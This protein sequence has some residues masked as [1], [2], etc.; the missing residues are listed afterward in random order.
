MAK[1]SHEFAHL[2]HVLVEYGAVPAGDERRE[3]LRDKL[4]V[5]FRPVAVNIA[6]RYSGRGEPLDDLEQVA[7]IGLLHALDRFEPAHGRDFLAYAVPTIMGEVRRYFRDSAWSVKTPRS[8]KDRYVAVNAS[9]A[10]VAQD[11]GRAPTASELAAR[12]GLSREEVLEAVAARSSF[13]SASL[14]EALADD[15]TALIDILGVID[16]DLEH[17]ELR[18]LVRDLVSSLPHRE[19]HLL[20]LRFVQEK[21]QAE[22]G[23]ELFISQMHVSR[24]LT[25][26]LA[27]LRRETEHQVAHAAPTG[28]A[29]PRRAPYSALHRSP[30]SLRHAR[31]P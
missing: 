11:L 12:L 16:A 20:V 8:V 28:A 30:A 26:T 15:D 14:D 4:A 5:G 1:R 25:R 2:D 24:L 13:Q 22:I 3:E 10:E 23:A 29:E 27:Q 6:R 21:T 9:T 17:V 31:R 18:A 19:R 7:S